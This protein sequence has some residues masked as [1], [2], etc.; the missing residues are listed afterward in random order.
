MAVADTASRR[1]VKERLA[2]GD[3][4]ATIRRTHNFLIAQPDS[5]FRT[6]EWGRWHGLSGAQ[7]LTPK[8][9]HKIQSATGRKARVAR[10]ET[11]ATFRLRT[12]AEKAEAQFLGLPEPSTNYQRAHDA[13]IEYRA[14]HE[15]RYR[16]AFAEGSP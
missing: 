7:P 10:R 11:R 14:T 8:E 12:E 6:A 4:A 3:S 13:G 1:F 5:Y 16:E 9:I 2:R 15:E